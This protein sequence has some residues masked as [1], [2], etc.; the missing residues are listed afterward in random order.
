MKANQYAIR[1]SNNY[2][3]DSGRYVES[4]VYIPYV[5]AKSETAARKWFAKQY[6]K[7]TVTEFRLIETDIECDPTVIARL[8]H[9]SRPLTRLSTLA[10]MVVSPVGG[11]KQPTTR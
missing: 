3:T 9:R 11:A 6:P 1:A 4:S 5:F 2:T 7:A 8:P 10:I